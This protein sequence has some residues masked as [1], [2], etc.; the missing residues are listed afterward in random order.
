MGSLTNTSLYSDQ[1]DYENNFL[2]AKI[3]LIIKDVLSNLL[4]DDGNNIMLTGWDFIE[5]INGNV[6]ILEVN[7]NPSIN[8]Q[9]IQVLNE[10]FDWINT[11]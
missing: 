9:H 1:F 11:Q 5:D 10:F 8:I 7:C 4:K 3:N 2:Y 6:F